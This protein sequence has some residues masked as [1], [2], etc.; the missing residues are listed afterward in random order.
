LPY[1]SFLQDSLNMSNLPVWSMYESKISIWEQNPVT[2]AK[3]NPSSPIVAPRLVRGLNLVS[4]VQTTSIEQPGDLAQDHY[5]S[6]EYL[7]TIENFFQDKDEQFA[8]NELFSRISTV[9]SPKYQKRFLIE[10]LY[11]N[12]REH[13]L[14]D[15]LTLKRCF[16]RLPNL[17]STSSASALTEKS[18]Q[19]R[20]LDWE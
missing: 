12:K 20:V 5:V 3:I 8:L 2:G 7:F 15:L 18:M 13:L 14:D 6:E 10:L 16:S 17:S 4:S 9:N 11:S 19:F 1:P